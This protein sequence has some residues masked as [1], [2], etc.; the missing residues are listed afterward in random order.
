MTATLELPFNLI[1]GLENILTISEENTPSKYVGGI[2]LIRFS[3]SQDGIC[4][5]AAAAITKYDLVPK[6]SFRRKITWH[7]FQIIAQENQKLKER[8]AW[9]FRHGGGCAYDLSGKYE[10]GDDLIIHGYQ[11]CDKYKSSLIAVA[12]NHGI[13]LSK[14]LLDRVFSPIEQELIK[15]C[16]LVRG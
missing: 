14:K 9:S 2:E 1:S 15:A 12:A 8:Q 7:P 16:R 6:F 4:A 3:G 11:P 13:L 5:Y 10:G